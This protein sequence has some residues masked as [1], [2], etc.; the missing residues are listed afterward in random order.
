METIQN[1]LLS[2]SVDS[3]GIGTLVI[4]QTEEST[5]LFSEAFII[6]YI[7]VAQQAIAD[8][9]VKG[10]IVTSG[11]PIFMAGADL[12]ALLED[13][14][15]KKAFTDSVINLHTGLRSIETGGKP[16]VAAI[17]GT[18]LGGG[19]E[20]C[21]AC[22]HRIALNSTK[23]KIG[24]PEIKVGLFPGGG[25]TVKAPYLLGIQTALMYL[26]QGIE[27][28][29]QKALKD[30]LIDAVAETEEEMLAAA[31]AFI[32]ATP[33]PVQ[34][35]D[36]KRHKIPGG[37]IW[38]P[39]GIQ[40][41]AGAS[42]NVGKLTHGNYPSAQKIVKVIHDGLQIPID[43]ALE[44][45]ARN[46]THA[47]CSKEAKNMIRTGFF[48]I[49][50]A[51]KG[52]ARPKD[53]PKYEI[54][55]LG[56]L[57]AG[58]MG[59]GIAY[60]SAK[61]GMD[62]VLK[63]VSLEGAEKGKSYSTALLDKAIAKKRST[64]EKKE[65]LLAKITPTDNPNA[66][67]G[68]DL[69]IEAV[70]ENVDLKD[71]VTKETEAVLAEDKI[72][73]SNTSTIPISLLAKSSKR[74]E[75]FIGIHFFSPVDKM[76]LVEI[77][78]GEKTE[79]KAIAAA[80]DYTVA[81]KKVPIVV[82]DSRGFFTSRCFGTFVSEGMFLLEEG[83]PA[84]MLERI[85]TKIGMPVG[86]LAVHDEVSLTLS[87]H[88]FESDPAEKQES[89]KRTYAIVKNLVENHNRTGK[90]DGAGF[91]DYPKGGQKKLWP[92]LKEIFTPNLEAV[93]EETITKRLLSRQVLESYRCLDE[94]VLRSSTDGDIGS[95]LGWGFPIFTG[96]ALSYI[97]YVGM[98]NFIADCDAF[99][100]AYGAHWEV[101]QSLRALAAAGK[102]IHDF[103]K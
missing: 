49:Q 84:P 76:P 18:A 4:N 14:T 16:F 101:P 15:D 55:K 9:N 97:D 36:N 89:E 87:V 72:Y 42:G 94:G 66:V 58:M 28:R 37:G 22:H 39:N 96:G 54:N 30:G 21:L 1:K 8:E 67:E 53:Q 103:G 27:A 85:A 69:I 79:D 80:V 57:G 48:A 33:N 93:S 25:G 10:V 12:R 83:V 100:T 47:V 88:I 17:N 20:L 35:W 13:I 65:A 2:F 75:N 63:D 44:V 43:R 19:L 56:V 5:N 52:K 82:N 59:A 50:D 23:I 64:P 24:F 26:L 91:Y 77:I 51:A 86:P 95:I 34:P 99:K 60:V 6:Q 68:S 41:L 3:D 32:L 31:K 81:I 90:R 61:A 74:P 102:S 40:T 70:F 92:G 7:E 62:V 46:F 45:E 11:K 78:V 29:P 98:D 38:T 71:R 73:G